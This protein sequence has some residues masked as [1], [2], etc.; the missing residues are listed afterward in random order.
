MSSLT[1]IL[2]VFSCLVLLAGGP[3]L[4]AEWPTKPITAIVGVAPG[5]MS[6]VSTRLIVEKFKDRL[7]QPVMVSNQGG[8]GGITGLRALLSAPP[9]GY[10]F[11]SGALSSALVAPFLL[12]A[13]PFDLDKFFFIGGYC[14]QARIVWAKPD[15]PYKNWPEFVEYARK[16]PGKISAGSGG[17]QLGLDVFKSVA[18]KEG[19]KLNFVMFKSGGEASTSILGG[20]VDV[21][22]TG[23]GTPA[24]Q[25]ARQGKLIPLIGL[26]PV[27]DPN[28]PNLKG[29]LD[30]GYPFSMTSD[31]GMA[32]RK[33]VPEPIR[34]RLEKA[35]KETLEDPGVR[36]TM[37][38]MGFPPRFSSGKDYE[39]MVRKN[40]ADV[41]RLSAY[42]KDVE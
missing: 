34:A 18:K 2:S 26:S 32:M 37:F 40:V 19:I 21:C 17:S 12:N 9:D 20:H 29:V 8:A 15:Q 5:G 16:N 23:T 38:T 41:P 24:Y 3:G 7:G 35:L 4:G 13:Q 14:V 42:V 1:L 11:S 30:W 10:T 28:F 36:T 27:P 6:D 39:A 22:E 33:G 31:Y 25:A